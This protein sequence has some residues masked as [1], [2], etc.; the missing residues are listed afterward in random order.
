MLLKSLFCLHGRDSRARFVLIS[1]GVYAA[2]S[3]AFAVFGA[4]FLMYFIALAGLPLLALTSVRRSVDASK[5]RLLAGLLFL[6]LPIY[7]ALLQVGAPPFIAALGLVLALGA[8]V[9]GARLPPQTCVDYRLGYYGP[10]LEL[11]LQQAVPRRRVEPVLAGHAA[12]GQTRTAPVEAHAAVDMKAGAIEA[13]ARKAADVEAIDIETVDIEAVAGDRD[14][15]ILRRDELRFDA[16]TR[17][18]P[19]PVELMVQDAI[20]D[21]SAEATHPSR[22]ESALIEPLFAEQRTGEPV[23]RASRA[24]DE[25]EWRIDSEDR[26]AEPQELEDGDDAEE[27]RRRRAEDKESGSMTELIRG[28]LE[29]LAPYR[30]YLVLPKRVLV[31]PKT[32]LSYLVQLSPR[33]R[34]L[35]GLGLGALG[36]FA[37]IWGVWPSSD[38]DTAAQSVVNAVPVAPAVGNRQTLEMPDGFSVALEGEVFIM[39]WLGETGQAHNI[40]SLATAKG[41][42]TCRTLVFNNGTEYRPVTVDL[43]ADSATEARFSPLDTAG[44]IVDLARRGSLGLCGYK[45]S[46]KGS[47]AVL[48]QNRTFANYLAQ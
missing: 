12:Q 39:R 21:G 44:I 20:I 3:L 15:Q 6:P 9:W 17:M 40:W 13:H 1:V 16:L 42:K 36:T 45:F 31:L 19:S 26:H 29:K 4:D 30:R 5:P 34:R 46:L 33:H 38:T 7:L 22:V 10:A 11:A 18:A 25:V 28:L 37:L 35:V 14:A 27:V 8:T 41:D 47:Q 32:A 2:I 43:T 48:E 24:A 23:R